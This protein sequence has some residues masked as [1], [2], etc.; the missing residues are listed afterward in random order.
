M[1]QPQLS[2]HRI[3]KVEIAK[4][5]YFAADE[6]SSGKAFYSAKLIITDDDGEQH[7]IELF[8]NNIESLSVGESRK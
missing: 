4:P 3:I 2:F 8:S 1:T 7:V 5:K 6:V